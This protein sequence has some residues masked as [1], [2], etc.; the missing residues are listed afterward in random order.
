M[1][2]WPMLP[3][4][5]FCL[6]PGFHRF[7]EALVKALQSMGG[8]P[9]KMK[10]PA[11]G[12]DAVVFALVTLAMMTCTVWMVALM[13]RSFSHCCN[14]RGGKAVA[15]FVVGLLV[16]EFLSKLLIGQLFHLA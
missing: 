15:G 7:S 3:V 14:V 1:A 9:A 13:W 16:A 10:L 8:D 11:A 4:S 6:A 12:M 5:L 2:R